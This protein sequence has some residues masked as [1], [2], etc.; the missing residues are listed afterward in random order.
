MALAHDTR[1]R[2]RVLDISPQRPS[3]PNREDALLDCEFSEMG[4][5]SHFPP[6]WFIVP[7]ALLGFLVVLGTLL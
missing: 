3:R 1:P 2:R 7:G 5:N 6:G 4:R